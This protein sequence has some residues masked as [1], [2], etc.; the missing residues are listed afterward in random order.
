MKTVLFL[1]VV[2][3]NV[4]KCSNSEEHFEEIKFGEGGGFTGAVTEYQIKSNGD[5]FL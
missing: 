3:L 2:I 5:I 4:S 1:F